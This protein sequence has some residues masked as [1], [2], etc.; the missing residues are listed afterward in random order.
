M[1]GSFPSCSSS[2]PGWSAAGAAARRWPARCR[3][4]WSRCWWSPPGRARFPVRE[5]QRGP[6]P[7]RAPVG[8]GRAGG[9]GQYITRS[10]RSR[11]MISTGRSAS[12]QASQVRS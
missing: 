4:G 6:V 1:T 9:A 5:L 12:S 7:Q 10:L 8:A 11:P 2:R 3:T